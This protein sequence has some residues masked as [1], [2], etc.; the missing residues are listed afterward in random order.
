MY[1]QFYDFH[2]NDYRKSDINYDFLLLD[3]DI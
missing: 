2:Y 3:T 1:D